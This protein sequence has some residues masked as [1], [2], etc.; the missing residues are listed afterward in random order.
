MK[1]LWLL[2]VVFFASLLVFGKIGGT[3]PF[4]VNSVTTQKTDTFSVSGEGKALVKPDI[5]LV[6]AGVS[7]TGQTVSQ[8]QQQ[9]IT[10]SGKIVSA[11]KDLGIDS[12]DIKTIN[13]SINPTYDFRSGTQKI[14]GYSAATTLQVKVRTLDKT[15]SVI[16]AATAAGANQVGGV[17]FDVD[18]PAKGQNEARKMAV[19]E[20]KKKAQQAAETAGFTLGRIINYQE[21]FGGTPR[22]PV[23]LM[24]ADRGSA[25]NNTESTIEP[26][27][28][29]ITSTV[30]LSYELR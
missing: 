23:A 22:P 1:S 12:K 9:I 27:S 17:T 10:A 3:I 24:N 18:D 21:E 7:A 20:A 2:P 4:A 5:A 13:Y 28:S 29:E 26:G 25:K 8:A 11:V 14:I 19:L 15:S 6:T 30:T 16:D